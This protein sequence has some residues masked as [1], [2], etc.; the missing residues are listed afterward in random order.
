MD[1][2]KWQTAPQNRLHASIYGYM[3]HPGTPSIATALLGTD[4]NSCAYSISLVGRLKYWSNWLNMFLEGL[5][6]S[7]HMSVTSCTLI[8]SP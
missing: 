5:L 2:H 1:D 4:N 3:C 8:I 7:L 6:V